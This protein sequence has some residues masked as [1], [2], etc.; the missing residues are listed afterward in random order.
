MDSVGGAEGLIQLPGRQQ[1]G[2]QEGHHEEPRPPGELNQ[3]QGAPHPATEMQPSDCQKDCAQGPAATTMS[4]EEGLSKDQNVAAGQ[5]EE[6]KMIEKDNEQPAEKKL[7]FLT[8]EQMR[9]IPE[10]DILFQRFELGRVLGEG[11]FGQVRMAKRKVN[12]E[13]VAIKIDAVHCRRQW[14]EVPGKQK[15]VPLEVGLM[16]RVCAKPSCPSII[17]MYEYIIRP[18]YTFIV[19]E[20][21]ESSF[22]LTDYMKRQGGPLEEEQGK[23][24]FQQIVEAVM[25]CHSRGVFHSDIKPRNILF[26]STTGQVKLIDFGCGGFLLEEK[27]ARRP[28]TLAY[29]PP[30]YFLYKKYKPESANVW[31]LG[32]TLF[33]LLSGFRPF[34]SSM[35]IM[36]CSIHIPDHLSQEYPNLNNGNLIHACSSQSPGI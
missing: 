32:I 12:N 35:E 24:V 34:Q 25:H 8:I 18:S 33:E 28:G 19:M 21:L 9:T 22:S 23:S 15:K 20:L 29:C 31:S 1:T 7:S 14:V 6:Q 26:Q 16:L 30:E 4:P 17:Q 3:A 27:Y 2:V 11:G 5:R 36:T 10:L 13:A